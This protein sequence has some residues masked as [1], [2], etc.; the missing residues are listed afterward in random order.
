MAIIPDLLLTH[1]LI[2]RPFSVSYGSAFDQLTAAS[3]GLSNRAGEDFQRLSAVGAP[4]NAW[5]LEKKSGQQLVGYLDW[6]KP[7][8]AHLEIAR[9]CRLQGYATQALD[10]VSRFRDD[11]TELCFNIETVDLAARSLLEKCGYQPLPESSGSTSTVQYT[12]GAQQQRQITLYL[13]DE[14]YQQAIQNQVLAIHQALHIDPDYGITRQLKLVVEATEL[15]SIGN[16]I[17]GRQQYLTPTA[18]TA[19][20]TLIAAAAADG[21]SLK[22]V[23]AYRGIIYQE[24]ILQRKLAAG[25]GIARI[26]EVSAAPGYSEHHSGCA[27]DITT[28][29]AAPLTEAFENSSA[30]AWL[31]SNGNR[32]GFRMSYPRANRHRMAYEPWHWAFVDGER[33]S[34]IADAK[35]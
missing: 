16:D 24:S 7:C 1:E 10:R 13:L 3:G 19:W 31:S 14:H 11:L 15:A 5:L 33:A 27:V 4:R 22:A 2:L 26:L 9:D 6:S 34:P 18:A 23:S 20:Q 35:Y 25:T 17:Y 32:F 21:E 29:D 28:P 12:T 30:F 8:E